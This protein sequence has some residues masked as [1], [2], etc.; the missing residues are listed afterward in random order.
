MVR[1]GLSGLA[2]VIVLI[3]SACGSTAPKPRPTSAVLTTP[4]AVTTTTASPPPTNP[5]SPTATIKQ[6]IHGFSRDIERG[7]SAA[8]ATYFTGTLASQMASTTA[9]SMLGISSSP[10][11]YSFR[12]TSQTPVKATV[13]LQDFFQRGHVENRLS[14]RKTSAGWRISHISRT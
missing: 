9:R 10:T 7:N 6:T 3:L 2:L 1:V 4:T 8:A 14:L 11:R 12:I 13:T 5:T